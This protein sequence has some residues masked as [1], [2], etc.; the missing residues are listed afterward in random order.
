MSPA[1]TP[2][3]IDGI[4]QSG[5]PVALTPILAVSPS[6]SAPA[7]A[8]YAP[9]IL[10]TIPHSTTLLSTDFMQAIQQVLAEQ[11]FRQQ[12]PLETHDY[13]LAR[14]HAERTFRVGLLVAKLASSFD[15]P[16]DRDREPRQTTPQ[17]IAPPAR[18]GTFPAE[19]RVALL[20]DASWFV[21]AKDL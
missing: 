5:N 20:R 3:G 1:T 7:T 9:P 11:R 6:V 15:L 12:H 13:F 21:Q 17:A 4:S 8:M 16:I 10:P 19:P 18:K 14:R 2:E